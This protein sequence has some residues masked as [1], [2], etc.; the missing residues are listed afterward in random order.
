MTTEAQKRFDIM[1]F[2]MGHGVDEDGNKFTCQTWSH[3]LLI[4]TDPPDT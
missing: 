4:K 2:L 1:G 3:E